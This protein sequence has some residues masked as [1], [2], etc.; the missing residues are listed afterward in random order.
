MKLT[1]SASLSLRSN[2]RTKYSWHTTSLAHYDV[3][4]NYGSCVALIHMVFDTMW[5]YST[6]SGQ[7]G[8]RSDDAIE[9]LALANA[10]RI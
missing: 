1:S 8:P 2:E 4:H 9:A 5:P 6:A 10:F 3:T 7:F